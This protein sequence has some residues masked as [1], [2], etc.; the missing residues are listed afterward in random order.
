MKE[1]AAKKKAAVTSKSTARKFTKL[2][3][4]KV[5]RHRHLLIGKPTQG[6]NRH[7]TKTWPVL[8]LHIA[9]NST[10]SDRS[11]PLYCYLLNVAEQHCVLACLTTLF[12]FHGLVHFSPDL[13]LSGVLGNIVPRSLSKVSWSLVFRSIIVHYTVI[14]SSAHISSLWDSHF[15]LI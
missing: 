3:N 9:I 15:A 11:W 6:K 5:Q 8:V 2:Q 13:L 12:H 10:C 4:R 14:T 1:R 7:L